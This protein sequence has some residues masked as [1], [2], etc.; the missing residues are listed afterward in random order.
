MYYDLSRNCLTSNIID[1]LSIDNIRSANYDNHFINTRFLVP[2]PDLYLPVLPNIYTIPPKSSWHLKNSTFYC[3]QTLKVNNNR[4]NVDLI[5]E[6][7]ISPL[8]KY[9][10]AVELSGGLDSSIIIGILRKFGIDPYLIGFYS[11][12]Y[13]F[14][15]E[16]YIQNKLIQSSTRFDLIESESIH[17]CK[18]LLYTPFHQLPYHSSLWYYA[19]EKISNRCNLNNIDILFNGMSGDT[20]FCKEVGD[21]FPYEWLSWQMDYGWFNQYVFMP[22]KIKYL[23]TYSKNLAEEIFYLRKNQPYDAKK[24]WARKYF[25]RYL[26]SELVNYYYKADHIVEF[27]DG[28]KKAYKEIETLFYVANDFLKSKE[29]SIDHYN[30][31]YDQVDKYD[32]DHIHTIFSK[33]SFANWI[34]SIINHDKSSK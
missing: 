33:V 22:K 4:Y 28:F 5:L 9:N 15:T 27:L 19:K 29:F 32:S 1:D 11:N 3:A 21:G 31:L 23:P 26:P 8:K 17:P 24:I 13:E 25:N 14:R 34:Y 10:V 2:S 30:K 18:N 7:L 20:I 6:K 12:K 16:R